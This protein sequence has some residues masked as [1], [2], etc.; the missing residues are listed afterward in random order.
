M[1]TLLVGNQLATDLFGEVNIFNN[2]FLLTVHQNNWNNFIFRN[3]T[4][5]IENGSPHLS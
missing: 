1:V 3:L 5:K 4:F 2:F